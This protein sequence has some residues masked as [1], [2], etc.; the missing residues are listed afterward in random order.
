MEQHFGVLQTHW[1]ITK[2]LS[3]FYH[4]DTIKDICMAYVITHNMIIED[5]EGED[6]LV[7]LCIIW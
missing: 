5:E 1:A 4:M 2:I 7:W 6:L 3:W